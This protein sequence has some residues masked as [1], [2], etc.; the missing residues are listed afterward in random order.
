MRELIVSELLTLDG[1]MEAPGGEP[2]HPHSGWAFDYMGEDVIATKLD[3]VLEAGSLLL[4]R[5]TY[6]S[7]ASAWPDRGGDH[8]VVEDVLAG[9]SATVAALA[10][11]LNAMP[12]HVASTTL[13]DPAWH[14]TTAIDGDV[15]AA[16]AR[17]KAQDG[18][19]IVVNGSRTL[20]QALIAHDLVD[21]YRLTVMPVAVGSGD[22]LFPETQRKTSLDLVDVRSFASGAVTQT[23]RT[24]PKRAG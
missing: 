10:N 2:G 16:V 22:R 11:R 5:V 15:P 17:L 8:P 18:G 1:V 19:P 20:V 21:V 9:V 12:K 24:S 6:E 7:F 4:G 13:R 14:N 3:E 23:Y